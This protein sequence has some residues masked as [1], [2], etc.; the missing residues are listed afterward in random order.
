[1]CSVK[2]SN[3]LPVNVECFIR[4][5][6]HPRSVFLVSAILHQWRERTELSPA[7]EQLLCPPQGPT[8]RAVSSDIRTKVGIS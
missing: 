4:V 1:M 8:A 6:E 2:D 5:V 3:Q 7:D